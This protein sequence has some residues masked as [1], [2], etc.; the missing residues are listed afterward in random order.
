MTGR[1][2]QPQSQS[3]TA[4]R[5]AGRSVGRSVGRTVRQTAGP[6]VPT[7]PTRAIRLPRRHRSGVTLLEILIATVVLLVALG[8]LGTQTGVAV[9]AASRV[10]LESIGSILCESLA[11]ELIATQQVAEQLRP[12][13]M[14]YHP[15]W[16]YTVDLQESDESKHVCV[17]HRY[18]VA[19]IEAARI[20]DKF[21]ATRANSLRSRDWCCQLRRLK[22]SLMWFRGEP[23]DETLGHTGR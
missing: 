18:R 5:T 17:G 9:R 14:S 6:T 23:T 4:G 8:A 13:Q 16:R 7:R 15:N 21:E 20:K 1:T 11:D 22:R 3:Q 2:R 12:K 10:E 19:R